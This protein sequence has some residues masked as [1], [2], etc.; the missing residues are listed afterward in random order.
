MHI[1]R[2]NLSAKK[3]LHINRYLAFAGERVSHLVFMGMGEPLENYDGVVRALRVLVD[4]D[5]YDFSPRKI[6]VSTVG[7]VPNIRR[8]M[9]ENI[10]VNLALSLHAPN[11]QIRKEVV[12]YARRVALEDVLR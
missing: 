5:F 10:R 3:V 6:T 2:G 12:P 7:V 11:Q 1:P 9:D 4:A 8:L